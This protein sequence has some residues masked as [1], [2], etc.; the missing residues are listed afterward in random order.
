MVWAVVFVIT[1]VIG[2]VSFFSGEYGV[3]F[4]VLIFW[5]IS[6][7]GIGS[8]GSESTTPIE[9]PFVS[10]LDLQNNFTDI[11]WREMEELTGELFRRKGYSVK[12]TQSSNDYGIDVGLYFFPSR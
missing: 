8:S 10:E 5:V 9:S 2:V 12:V 11:S 4:V 3:W 6:I 7:I 1:L